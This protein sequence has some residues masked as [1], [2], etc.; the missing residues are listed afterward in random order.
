MRVVGARKQ[1][2]REEDAG[3]LRGAR[4]DRPGSKGSES[5]RVVTQR[6]SGRGPGLSER[7]NELGAPQDPRNEATMRRA[8]VKGEHV[9]VQICS[10][11][12]VCITG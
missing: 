1:C 6:S 4:E 2:A 12:E 3:C 7:A 11:Q 8:R 9:E 5:E 10:H